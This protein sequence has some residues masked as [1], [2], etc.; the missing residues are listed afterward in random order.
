M[1][2]SVGAVNGS[3]ARGSRFIARIPPDSWTISA[4]GDESLRQEAH[5]LPGLTLAGPMHD[6][7]LYCCDQRLDHQLPLSGGHRATIEGLPEVVRIASVCLFVELR[8]DGRRV[9][10]LVERRDES[11]AIEAAPDELREQRLEDLVRPA[12]SRPNKA[13]LRLF[14]VF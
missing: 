12:R 2:R 11:V 1:S 6:E 5:H 13:R 4:S 3:A 8:D 9:Q 10:S 7:T 14:Q